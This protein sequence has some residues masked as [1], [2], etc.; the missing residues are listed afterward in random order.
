MVGQ[1]RLLGQPRLLEDQPQLRL[2]SAPQLRV[3]RPQLRLGFRLSAPQL[4][5]SALQLR[6]GSCSGKAQLGVSRPQLRL[7]FRVSAPQLR[8]PGHDC[9]AQLR[10]RLPP[11]SVMGLFPPPA[12]FP[13]PSRLVT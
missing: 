13:F 10:L 8:G 11:V 12:R 5:V 7:G 6:L 2:V 3:S 9:Q 1:V 4:R